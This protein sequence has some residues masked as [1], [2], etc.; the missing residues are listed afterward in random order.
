MTKYPNYQ[1]Y[2]IKDGQF[3]GEFE[4][5]YKDFEE[6][7]F[8]C[9]Q[10]FD[11]VRFI[12]LNWMK[13]LGVTKVIELGCGLGPFTNLVS[14]AGFD[15]LG[16][17][18]SPT[19][20]KKARL[21]HPHCSFEVGDILD[22]EIYKE[23]KPEVV[24]LA[25]IT[26]YILDKLDEFLSFMRKEFPNTFL[27]NFLSVYPKDAQKY[28]RDKFTCLSEI[29]EYFGMN[30]L[31]WGEIGAKGKEGQTTYFLGNWCSD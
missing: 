6:P 24:I 23:F 12:S 20:I 7:W 11:T 26:W 27:I 10:D 3:I 16:V 28:G 9:S 5:L 22:Y 1:D 19:A 30:Y 21:N 25:E 18:I 4:Q 13:N 31:E 8:Q 29:M 17:D 2:V 14:S 15:V